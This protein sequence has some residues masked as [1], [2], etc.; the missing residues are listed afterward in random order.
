MIGK[1]SKGYFIEFEESKI[2][3][4]NQSQCESNYR[5][6]LLESTASWVVFFWG[7]GGGGYRRWETTQAFNLPLC[8]SKVFAFPRFYYV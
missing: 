2:K 7:G 3:S 1:R 5:M 6:T 8:Y 4:I